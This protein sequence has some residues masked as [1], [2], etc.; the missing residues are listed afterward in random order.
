M[1]AAIPE[2]LVQ[3]PRYRMVLALTAAALFHPVA[4]QDR[5][6][7][8]MSAYI[9]TRLVENGKPDN[10]RLYLFSFSYSDL[11]PSACNVQSLVIHNLRCSNSPDAAPLPSTALFISP[12]AYCD[13]R[14]C[15]DV[16]FS[17]TR[18][19]LGDGKFEFRFRT[20]MGLDLAA[21]RASHQLIVQLK[22]YRILHYSG[23]LSNYSDSARTIK[24][25]TYVPITSSSDN[26]FHE[27]NI[28]CSRIA[29]PGIRK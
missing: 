21:G 4:A 5:D 28:G 11:D 7:P 25:A 10:D 14:Q 12:P 1:V 26:G 17:C 20:P 13:K 18:Q 3:V 9:T 24:S 29:V 27:L 15:G 19:A 8:W 23:S 16:G 6:V 2:I 22:P